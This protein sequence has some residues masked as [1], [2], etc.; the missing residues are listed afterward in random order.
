MH[1]RGA[2]TDMRLH[3]VKMSVDAPSSLQVRVE[4]RCSRGLVRNWGQ[5]ACFSALFLRR[6]PPLSP[7]ISPVKSS[8][9]KPP[10][11]DRHNPA[12]LTFPF[13]LSSEDKK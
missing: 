7:V 5:A 13:P 8:S 2:R 9:L 3:G 12:L 11:N 10:D 6:F 1:I 4:T